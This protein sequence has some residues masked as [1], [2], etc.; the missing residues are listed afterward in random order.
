MLTTPGYHRPSGPYLS[1]RKNWSVIPDWESASEAWETARDAARRLLE[2][3]SEF[4]FV[5][6]ADRVVLLAALL[7]SLQRRQLES[8]P[9]VAFSAHAQRTGKSMLAESLGILAIGRKPPAT[10]IGDGDEDEM[11]KSFIGIL[12]S[13]AQLMNLDNILPGRP[14]DSPELAKILTQATFQG[15]ILGTNNMPAYP[16]NLLITATGNNFSVKG[17]LT[18]RTLVCMQDPNMEHP[19]KRTFTITNLPAYLHEHRVELV[20]NALTILKAWHV[21]G[22]PEQGVEAWGGF[23]QWS[24]EIREPIMWL[25]LDDLLADPCLTRQDVAAHDPER[26]F[27]A[28]VLEHWYLVRADRLTTT[29]EILADIRDHPS[30]TKDFKQAILDVAAEP[31][32]PDEINS[33]R[34]GNWCGRVAGRWIE[35]FKLSRGNGKVH[36]AQQWK[37]ERAD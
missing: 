12:R 29:A 33:R 4:P 35:G 26:E 24:R 11:R 37:V 30:A 23:D 13:G 27:D 17:D 14:L 8:A 3:F 6:E 9:L 34:F 7:T 36:Q 22:K 10:S 16:T 20:T 15:R 32:Q 19:E 28:V 31:K 18:S 5:T 1:L 21:A 25:G 2:P